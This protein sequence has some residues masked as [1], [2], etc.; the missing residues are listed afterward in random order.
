MCAE[1]DADEGIVFNKDK[2][3]WHSWDPPTGKAND[4]KPALPVHQS[5]TLIK[6][7]AAH[8]LEYDVDA[9]IPGQFLDPVSQASGSVVYEVV[10]PMFERDFQLVRTASSCNDPRAEPLSDFDGGK[11]DTTTSSRHEESFAA[12]QMSAMG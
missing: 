12:P 2:I 11:P 10:R 9:Y 6:Y 8:R 7:V 4:K 3:C 1:N 5:C